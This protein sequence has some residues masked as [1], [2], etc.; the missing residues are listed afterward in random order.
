[1]FKMNKT[2][3]AGLLVSCAVLVAGCTSK[4]S[5]NPELVSF[6][7]CVTDAGAVFYGTEWCPHCKNQ[8]A[9]F[10]VAA[11]EK[12][13]FIDCDQ[14]KAL[15]DSANVTG[16][17]TWVFR[18]GSSIAGTQSLEAIAAKTNCTLPTVSTGS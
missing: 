9:L 18:D 13:K 2:L 7:Q 8:K 17:P 12:I 5:D 1:M 10:G 14:Q 3:V 4:S 11:M 6:A 16:Y 15:C